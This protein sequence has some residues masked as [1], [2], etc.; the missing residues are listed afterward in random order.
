[1]HGNIATNT[2][3][4]IILNNDKTIL[5]CENKTEQIQIIFHYRLMNSTKLTS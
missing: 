4:I 3:L 2:I 1:M 5:K